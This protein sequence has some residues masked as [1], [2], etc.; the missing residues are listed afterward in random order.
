MSS[1]DEN[2]KN[3]K[4]SEKTDIEGLDG[5]S[6]LIDGALEGCLEDCNQNVELTCDICKEKLTDPKVLPC[7]HSFCQTCLEKKVEEVTAPV[8][9]E[10]TKP[11]TCPMQVS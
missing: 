1:G 10:P 5:A 7:L 2:T 4:V 3:P 8:D 9:G 11:L 6:S